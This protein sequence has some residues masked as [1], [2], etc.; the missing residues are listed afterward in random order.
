MLARHVVVFWGG[1]AKSRYTH[2]WGG[3]HADV[4]LPVLCYFVTWTL[5]DPVGVDPIPSF[6]QLL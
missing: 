2:S 3:A 5:E 4:F 6:I 1:T